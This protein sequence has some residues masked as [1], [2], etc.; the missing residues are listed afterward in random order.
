[1]THDGMQSRHPLDLEILRTSG[2]EPRFDAPMRGFLKTQRAELG[3]ALKRGG[4]LDAVSLGRE[5]AWLYR[6]TFRTK[7][8]TRTHE[9]EPPQVTERHDFA[10]RFLPEYLR[11]ANRF[12][13]LLRIGPD[14]CQAF[15]PNVAPTGAVCVEIYSG[16]PLVAIAL[17]LHDLIRGKL[18]N[19]KENDCLNPAACSFYRNHVQQPLDDRPLFGTRARIRLEKVSR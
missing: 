17:S 5:T 10:L 8:L 15:H 11:A 6:L 4:L 13:M 12:S 16:E 9:N 1:M 3:A 7:G 18:R 19:V 14:G 2:D